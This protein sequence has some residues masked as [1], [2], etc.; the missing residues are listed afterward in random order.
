MR[1]RRYFARFVMSLVWLLVVFLATEISL[2]TCDTTFNNQGPYYTPHCYD[3]QDCNLHDQSLVCQEEDC[4]NCQHQN[5]G[6]SQFCVESYDCGSI[7][8]CS[9]PRC[10]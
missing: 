4:Q 6:Y 5:T 8:G 1:S 3:D 2:A 10:T 9:N 7:P